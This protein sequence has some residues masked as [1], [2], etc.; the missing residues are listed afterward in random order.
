[1]WYEKMILQPYDTSQKMGQ[2]LCINSNL[3]S[4]KVFCQLAAKAEKTKKPIFHN[5]KKA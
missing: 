1:M 4:V 5:T 2:S 3:Q